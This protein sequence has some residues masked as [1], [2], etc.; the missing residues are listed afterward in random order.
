MV[1]DDCRESLDIMQKIRD[2]FGFQVTTF[3]AAEEALAWLHGSA[4]EEA[5]V[6]LIL[7]DWQMPGMDGYVAKPVNQDRLFQTLWHSIKCPRATATRD[8]LRWQPL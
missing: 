2:G 8:E 4:A 3:D 7:M 6:D 1:V 5:P